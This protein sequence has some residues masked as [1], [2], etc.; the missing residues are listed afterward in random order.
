MKTYHLHEGTVVI[1]EGWRDQTMNVFRLPGKNGGKEAA[2]V[3]TR[4]YETALE[5]PLEYADAQQEAA[6]KAFAGFKPLGRNEAVLGG[7]PAA[8]VDYQWRAN[9]TVM[10]RQRQVYVRHQGAMLTVTLSGVVSEFQN[11]EPAWEQVMA[12]FQLLDRNDEPDVAPPSAALSLPFVFALS[13][14]ERHLHVYED[15]A[16]ACR[17]VDAF[18]VEDGGWV[19]F[20]STG[21][22]LTVN[23]LAKNRRGMFSQES[24]KYMLSPDIAGVALPLQQRLRGATLVK[25]LA[26]LET[27][28]SVEVQLAAAGLSQGVRGPAS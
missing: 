22:P 7:Q 27:M 24:G 18:E 2:I 26:P 13:T 16:D 15:E 8:V 12:S 21:R 5:S 4:D 17:Q 20:S 25:P 19:F 28:N 10:L 1:P 3:I 9:G 6:R 14:A 23:F 11:L